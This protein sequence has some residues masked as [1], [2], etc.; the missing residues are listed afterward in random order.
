MIEFGTLKNFGL[1]LFFILALFAL[2]IMGCNS[3]SGG[4]GNGNPGGNDNPIDDYLYRTNGSYAFNSNTGTIV[5]QFTNSTFPACCGPDADDFTVNNVT[6]GSTTMVWP[7]NDPDDD[8]T[9]WTRDSGTSG[10]IVGTWE[11]TQG[12]ERFCIIFNSDGTLQLGGDCFFDGSGSL[13]ISSADFCDDVISLNSNNA[14]VE[15]PDADDDDIE[16]MARYNN[17]QI[18]I[19][20]ESDEDLTPGTIFDIVADGFDIEFQG[21]L[22]DDCW[23]DDEIEATSGTVTIGIYTNQ[24]LTGSFDITLEN[25]DSLTGSFDVTY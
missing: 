16:I 9:F 17:G 19:E 1:K 11:L 24:R 2:L 6:V 3:G 18:G 21:E 4:G 25:G 7:A 12:N 10:D 22:V 5:G 20:I 14:C 15:L 13:S 23:G 8:N